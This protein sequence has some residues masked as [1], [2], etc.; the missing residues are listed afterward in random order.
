MR[1]T[2]AT[3]LFINVQKLVSDSAPNLHIST[4]TTFPVYFIPVL[5]DVAV[6]TT[7]GGN[8]KRQMVGLDCFCFATSTLHFD[9]QGILL[10]VLRLL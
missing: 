1:Q 9:K 10:I 5:P 3:Y 6:F 4:N 7:I 8:V 2:G